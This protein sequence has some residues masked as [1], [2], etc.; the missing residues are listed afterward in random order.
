MEEIDQT[1]ARNP[2]MPPKAIVADV[3]PSEAR[4][5]RPA[6]VS[7]AVALFWLDLLLSAGA[8]FLQWQSPANPVGWIGRA[9]TC[10]L[11]AFNA[12]VIYR[13]ST[14][15]NWA[16]W[17]ALGSVIFRNVIAIPTLGRILAASTTELD[18]AGNA[19]SVGALC[20]LFV[21]PGRRWFRTPA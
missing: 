17:V 9:V 14:G 19:L 12:W 13:I 16:R 2:Y 4:E 10:A 8:L 1:A 21:S 20:L 15:R 11:F 5:P 6:T 3:I 18:I 7:W